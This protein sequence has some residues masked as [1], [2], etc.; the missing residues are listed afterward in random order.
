MVIMASLTS[1]AVKPLNLTLG[2]LVT[3]E[4]AFCPI[5]AVSKFPYK[6]VGKPKSVESEAV[7]GVFFTAGKFWERTWDLCV[8]KPF[9]FVLFGLSLLTVFVVTMFGQ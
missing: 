3:N 2:Q 5:S 4:K 7:A 6:W 1:L 8:P 9:T